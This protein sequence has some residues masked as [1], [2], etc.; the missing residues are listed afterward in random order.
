MKMRR[1]YEVYDRSRWRGTKTEAIAFDQNGNEVVRG[2]SRFGNVLIDFDEALLH[3]ME[4]ID[5]CQKSLINGHCVCVCLGLA[6]ISGANTNELTLRLKRNTEQ[7]L[8]F[9]MMQ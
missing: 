5:R 9:L 8:K 6:G 3:I 1:T 7:K 2:M 4:A